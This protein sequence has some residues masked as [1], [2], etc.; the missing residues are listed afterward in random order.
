[1]APAKVIVL[2]SLLWMGGCSTLATKEAVV[3]CQVADGATT[4]YALAHGATELNPIPVPAILA[5][6]V[7]V[8]VWALRHSKEEWEAES[9]TA[10]AAIAAAGCIPAVNNVVVISKLPK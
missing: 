1:M 3:G 5:F 7:F 8:V 4:L 9:K 2:A 10:R 6:K